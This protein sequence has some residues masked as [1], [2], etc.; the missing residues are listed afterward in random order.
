MIAVAGIATASLIPGDET[1]ADSARQMVTMNR[2]Q[3]IEEATKLFMAGNCRR[4]CP[5]DITA[6]IG[7]SAFGR[8]NATPGT[9]TSPNFGPD[10]ATGYV[11]AGGVPV[12]ALGLPDD[13]ALDGYGRRMMY[14]V[15]KRATS[16]TGCV[17][18]TAGAIQVQ[19]KDTSDNVSRTD[20]AMAALISY[21][22][23]AH[24]AYPVGGGNARLNTGSTDTDTR[25][26]AFVDGS[27]A[28][29]FN[30]TVVR[31]ETTATFDD[32]VWYHSTRKNTCTYSVGD[33]DAAYGGPELVA[34]WYGW[35]SSAPGFASYV[36]TCGL[37]R[38]L[39]DPSP[40]H[41]AVLGGSSGARI[42]SDN[43]Y[44]LTTYYGGGKIY[45][46]KRNGM[47]WDT[48]PTTA[49]SA[50]CTYAGRTALFPNANYVVL[51][52]ESS[53][54][55]RFFKRSGDTWSLL[56]GSDVPSGADVPS[57]ITTASRSAKIAVDPL[58][59][60]VW[61]KHASDDN[62]K[63]RMYKRSGDSFSSVVTLPT[64]AATYLTATFSANGL[65]F[66]VAEHAAGGSPY[67]IKVYIYTTDTSRA[68]D[69]F[70][71]VQTLT[72]SNNQ[73]PMS[74]IPNPNLAFS[75]DNNYFMLSSQYNA[76]L[77]MWLITQSPANTFTALTTPTN[78]PSASLGEVSFSYNSKYF[79][80]SGNH[81][82][83]GQFYIFKQ[84]TPT[85]YAYET[86]LTLPYSGS[87]SVEFRH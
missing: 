34:T 5:A 29:S 81:V 44:L 22:K 6:A 11:V 47:N 75:P 41:T 32:I 14:M 70:T 63:G 59:V 3:K 30:R 55:V 62:A 53:P 17:G 12:V 13:Y 65:Y 78:V 45:A 57:G 18:I 85:T 86:T 82:N 15:D 37:W 52:C 72:V 79:A 56:S 71:L 84:F 40:Y 24:G 10:A 68:T 83:G 74:A 60:Y 27:F 42:S 23:N 4:P 66:A 2:M 61:V 26:N 46:Y 43:V 64:D 48:L 51:A 80:V 69:T 31:K 73:M 9:C 77:Y 49:L 87:T 20:T 28:T 25:T 8:E 1:G 76:K 54:Y 33:Y 16:V 35:A 7:S 58:G 19:V 38:K 39:P 67:N 50:T 36:K 21:G